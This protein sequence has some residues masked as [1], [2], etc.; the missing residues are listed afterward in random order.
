MQTLLLC[1]KSRFQ[2]WYFFLEAVHRAGSTSC[3]FQL[4]EATH[5]LWLLVSSSYH[6]TFVS[7]SSFSDTDSLLEGPLELHWAHPDSPG[8]SPHLRILGLITSAKSLLSCKVTHLN[9][10]G[11]RI[12]GRWAAWRALL[13]AVTLHHSHPPARFLALTSLPS[14]RVSPMSQTKAVKGRRR[15]VHGAAWRSCFGAPTPHHTHTHQWENTVRWK[16]RVT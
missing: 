9:P 4:L 10:P 2:P 15:S 3:L 13:P 5:I 12:W 11:I 8:K 16:S 1:W 6:C 14:V 7:I